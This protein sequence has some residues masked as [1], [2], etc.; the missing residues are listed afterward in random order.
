MVIEP[1]ITTILATLLHD[2][3]SNGTG[4]LEEIEDMF[5][6]D[7]CRIVE[8]LNKIGLIKYRGDKS[9]IERLQR[10]FLA[11]AQDVRSIFVKFADRIDNLRTLQYHADPKKAKRIAEESLS[12]YAPIAA[13]LGL[14]AF[15]ETMET[16]SLR[17]L[18]LDGYLHVT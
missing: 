4:T 17:E 6:V 11:M 13:R 2:S 15:K 18:D 14:Y 16:L 1:D 9:T 10:T 7:V 8:A 5:G 3:V 12:I